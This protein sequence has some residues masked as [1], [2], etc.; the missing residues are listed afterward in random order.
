VLS[1]RGWKA[2]STLAPFPEMEDRGFDIHQK[3]QEILA[4]EAEVLRRSFH[5]LTVIHLE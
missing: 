2:N 3:I 4:I 1:E 5:N